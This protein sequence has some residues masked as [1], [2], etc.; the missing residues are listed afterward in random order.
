MKDDT[1]RPN[2]NS[3]CL[4][5]ARILVA[6]VARGRAVLAVLGRFKSLNEDKIV[7][8]GLPLPLGEGWGEGAVN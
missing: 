1:H 5:R 6:V 7:P 3:C 2:S 4:V 8:R